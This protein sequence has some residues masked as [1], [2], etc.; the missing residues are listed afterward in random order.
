MNALVHDDVM[1]DHIKDS[2]TKNAQSCGDHIGI[3]L[4]DRPVVE[5][6]DG[7]NTE[8]H[9]KPVVSLQGMVVHGVMRPVP[10][11]KETVHDI[12]VREPGHKFPEEKNGDDDERAEYNGDPIHIILI[13]NE[14]CSLFENVFRRRPQN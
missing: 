5:Q 11:P 6:C 12:L 3:V 1:K 2:I 13:T 8:D 14:P 10:Y 9:G 4:N 7:W